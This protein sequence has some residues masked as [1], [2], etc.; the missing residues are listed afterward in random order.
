L[1]RARAS[2][3]IM[4]ASTNAAL[5]VAFGETT[6]HQSAQSAQNTDRHAKHA[7]TATDLRDAPCLQ[8]TSRTALCCEKASSANSN[9]SGT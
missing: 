2:S 3:R 1:Q 6:Q 4:M 7:R 5:R 9:A 8:C